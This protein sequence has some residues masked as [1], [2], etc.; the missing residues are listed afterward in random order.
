M[1]TDR[2]DR[3]VI[4]MLLLLLSL[5]SCLS[6]C[7]SM[8]PARSEATMAAEPIPP[9]TLGAGDV[10][11]IK[12]F[13]LP[14]LDESQIVR[15]DGFITLQLIGDV[16][17]QG[18]TPAN[19]HR[20]LVKLYSAQLK[21]PNLTIMVRRLNDSRVWVSGE[22]KRP[23]PVQMPGRLTVLEAVMEVGGGT[24]PTADLKQV[25]VVR[26]RDG[27]N[28]GCVINLNDVLKGKETETFYLQ[29]RDVVYV[30]PTAI[31]KVDDWVDQYIN[32]VVP[33]A[34]TLAIYPMGPGGA[35]QVG[36]DTTVSGR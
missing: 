1:L 26:Q 5:G 21:E 4:L 31:T 34:R 2:S 12:F 18:K 25:L 20:T 14:E 16:P 35:G 8:A 29:A 17:V 33:Q 6:G 32:K 27:R 30:P 28:Y 7:S 11:D 10:L 36:I 9:L 22:V 19:L 15:P 24:R 23:G 13:Y 3:Q